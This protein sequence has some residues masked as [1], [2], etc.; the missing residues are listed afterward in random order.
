MNTYPVNQV[1]LGGDH[2]ASASNMD[3]DTQL[4]ALK[5]YEE[6]LKNIRN[7]TIQGNTKIDP[8]IWEEIDNE[9][10][11]LT[12]DQKNILFQNDGYIEINNKL[13]GMVQIE[14]L[15]LVRGK[16]ENSEEGKK[17]LNSQLELVKKLKSNIIEESNKEMEIFKK[18]KEFSKSHSGVTY[19]EFIK[20]NI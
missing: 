13:Q 2:F 10:N 15:A 5:A 1:F 19:E 3:L 8:T 9:I 18:F 12:N 4:Q 17:L 7:R 11:P 14:L 20:S 6:K 16:I